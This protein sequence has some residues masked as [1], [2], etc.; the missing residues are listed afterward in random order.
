MKTNDEYYIIGIDGG[1]S[2]TR[3]ILMN[4]KGAT[5]ATAFDKGSNLSVYGETAAERIVHIVSSLCRTAKIS[6]DALDARGLVR[7]CVGQPCLSNSP[8]A[9]NPLHSFLL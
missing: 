3:G 6:F 4:E 5:L 8:S 9:T 1:A 7:G 2:K